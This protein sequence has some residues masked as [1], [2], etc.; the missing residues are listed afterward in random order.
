[1]AIQTIVGRIL[2][3]A[4]TDCSAHVRGVSV[5]YARRPERRLRHST[6]IVAGLL[7]ILADHTDGFCANRGADDAD[8]VATG[9][10]FR[11]TSDAKRDQ[12]IARMGRYL[13]PDLLERLSATRI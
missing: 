5:V 13:E 8:L 9:M 1:M 11:F 6:R 2:E 3:G 7:R 4:E 12:F 10:V